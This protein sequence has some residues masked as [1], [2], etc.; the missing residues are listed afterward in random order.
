MA[1][2]ITLEFE[3]ITERVREAVLDA[4]Q[5]EMK[6]ALMKQIEQA[7]QDVVYS[8]GA[9]PEAMSTRRGTIGSESVLTSEVGGGGNSYYLRIT[10]IATTQHPASDDE[11]DIVEKG[12]ANYRQPGPRPF[13]QTAVDKFVDSGEAES[14]LRSVL[15][16]HGL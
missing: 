9:S 5:N 11:A 6:T 3:K 1:N 15:A 10:N 16:A 14:I 7:A 13:M 4:L 12:Y 8:Y 2:T